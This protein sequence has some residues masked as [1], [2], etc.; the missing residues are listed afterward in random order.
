MRVVSRLD[1]VG[2]VSLPKP[3]VQPFIKF[4]IKMIKPIIRTC[5]VQKIVNFIN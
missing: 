5:F 4:K 2:K 1:N 3:V